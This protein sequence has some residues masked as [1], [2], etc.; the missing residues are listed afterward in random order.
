MSK[1]TVITV[2]VCNLVSGVTLLA[3]IPLIWRKKRRDAAKI[4]D[5]SHDG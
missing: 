2:V 3:C 4:M 1:F 5:P